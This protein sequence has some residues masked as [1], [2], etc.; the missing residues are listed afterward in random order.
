MEINQAVSICP[1]DKVH[2]L[3]SLTG[4]EAVINSLENEKLAKAI[5]IISYFSACSATNRKLHKV[6]VDC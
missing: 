2:V 3:F 5:R 4:R 1:V 6:F